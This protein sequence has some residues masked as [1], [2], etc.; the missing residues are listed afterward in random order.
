M[1][2]ALGIGVSLAQI[3]ARSHEDVHDHFKFLIGVIVDVTRVSVA[4]EGS[5]VSRRDIV[6]MALIAAR[7]EHFGFIEDAKKLGH[8]P[9]EFKEGA[10]AFCLFSAPRAAALVRSA[11]KSII[12]NPMVGSN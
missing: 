12:C 10:E 7:R 5:H 8:H 4:L 1:R 3:S 2:R 11:M 9:Q 6:E